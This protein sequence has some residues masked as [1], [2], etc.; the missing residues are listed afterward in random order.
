[1]NQVRIFFKHPHLHVVVR[2][3]KEAAGVLRRVDE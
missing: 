2:L 1:M 3:R